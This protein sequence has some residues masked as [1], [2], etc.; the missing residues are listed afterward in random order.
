MARPT[1]KRRR[2]T[3]SK[4]IRRTDQT[5]NRIRALPGKLIAVIL[6][7]ATL[8]GYV[9]ARPQ[10]GIQ[11]PE[12]VDL[13]APMEAPFILS[14]KGEFAVYH[15]QPACSWDEVVV[16]DV[17]L[18]PGAA[19]QLKGP[20]LNL[21]TMNFDEVPVFDS[22][23]QHAL[24]CDAVHYADQAP[25]PNGWAV[26]HCV[27]DFTITFR[28]IRF[29]HSVMTRHFSFEANALRDRKLH[30]TVRTLKPLPQ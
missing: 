9:V 20:S 30:W 10:I 15:V 27:V 18:P 28:P 13:Y 11:L 21:R 12:P 8:L 23:D 14:N 25:L 6:A 29:L 26:M 16:K 24:P 7:V 2:R 19:A 17:G 22:G 1:R 5:W 4:T 3:R